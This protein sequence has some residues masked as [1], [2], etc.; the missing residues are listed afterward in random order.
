[1]R[2]TCL[3]SEAPLRIN[4][5]PLN[6]RLELEIHFFLRQALVTLPLLFC[7]C[8]FDR[9]DGGS[10]TPITHFDFSLLDSAE[11]PLAKWYPVTRDKN[12]VGV[13]FA[14]HSLNYR[15]ETDSSITAFAS[16]IGHNPA[17]AGAYFDI[18]TQSAN[19]KTFLDAVHARGCIPFVTFDP[20]DYASPDTAHQYA[21]INLINQGY[22]DARLREIADALKTFANPVL[23]RFAHEMNGNW[24][25]Y[26]GVFCGG[27]A[28]TNRNGVPDGPENY[29]AAWR[30]VHDLFASEG[31]D[32][33]VWV[34]CPNGE[35]FPDESWNRPFRYFPGTDYVDLI[36]VDSYESPDKQTRD[37]EEGLAPFY[38]ELGL[39]MESRQA[40]SGF[41]I[42]PFG[43]SEFGTSRPD[44][45]SKTRWYASALNYI[46]GDG[47]IKINVLYNDRNHDRDF[48]ITGLGTRLKEYYD[49]PRFQFSFSPAAT[50]I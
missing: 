18:T 27:S 14:F 10:S 24:Y 33:L 34:F 11:N 37:L 1:L 3:K 25:P 32:E 30:H 35:S 8:V 13:K 26:S 20:K 9:E 43:L 21:F 29:I 19:L 36:S 31:A 23:F 45:A 49:N 6:A 16:E 47:R 50:G 15:Q 5:Q 4:S 46:A 40:D 12:V 41:V 38:N 17:I 2:G 28:D 42:R 39:F 44:T 48:S 7:A 22:F